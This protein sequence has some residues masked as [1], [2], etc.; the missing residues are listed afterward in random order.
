MRSVHPLRCLLLAVLAGAGASCSDSGAPSGDD[1]KP[2]SELNVVHVAPSSTPL[3]N[4][5]DELLRQAG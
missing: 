4:S 5:S 1:T 3:F 2:P